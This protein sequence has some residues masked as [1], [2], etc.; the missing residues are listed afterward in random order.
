M[1]ER[2][3]KVIIGSISGI[4][5]NALSILFQLLVTPMIL[6]YAGQESLG[7][8]AIIMQIIGYC[9]LLD[10]GFTVALTRFLCQTFD[11]KD[12]SGQF[13]KLLST[14]R[15]FLTFTNFII[16]ILL[17]VS[18][19]QIEKIIPGTKI[20]HN[21][22]QKALLLM[23]TWMIIR[24]FL[25]VYN[26]ALIATQDIAIIN[27]IA[28]FI[29]LF[30]LFCAVLFTYMGLGFLGL[31]IANIVAELLQFIFQ[32]IYFNKK[33]KHISLK[34][35][36]TNISLGFEIF[37]FGLRYWGVNLSVVLLL[38]SDNLIVGLIF[39]ILFLELEKTNLI[40]KLGF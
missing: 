34:W 5:Q 3:A 29:N 24:T 35:K 8:Y 39:V 23:A 11:Y 27:T 18:A 40:S 25:Y 38:G 32:K 13:T 4:A 26:F 33:Y 37:K 12:E 14:G 22:A 20:I 36:L 9:I 16:F 19:W 1:S 7:A 30:K 6:F 28:I 21:D 2:T 31:I 15:T 17:V 10:L